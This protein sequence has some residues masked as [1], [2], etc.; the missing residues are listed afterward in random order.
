[1]LRDLIDRFPYRYRLWV[2][3]TQ[4]DKAGAGESP[5]PI[6]SKRESAWALVARMLQIVVG[7]LILLWFTYRFAIRTFPSFSDGLPMFFIF[8]GAIW[9]G[10]GLFITGGELLAKNSK[11]DD[12]DDPS[13]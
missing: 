4:G 2:G 3:E 6:S 12:D 8:L 1:M 13:I 9:I 5:P 7:G 10:A 11:S